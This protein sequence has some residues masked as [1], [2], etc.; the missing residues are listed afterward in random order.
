[1]SMQ[2][3]HVFSNVVALR[4]NPRNIKKLNLENAALMALEYPETF[5][6]PSVSAI[7][8]LKVGDWVKLS[9][10][11][12]RFWVKVSG[13]EG[14]KWFGQVANKL[15]YSDVDLGD[16]IQFYRKNIYDAEFSE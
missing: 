16:T 4:R 15:I 8:K 13:F 1:M 10:P 11:Q 14:K 9:T 2:I 5:S 7:K 3:D 6:L 12:E